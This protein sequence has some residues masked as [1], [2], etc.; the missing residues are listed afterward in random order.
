M[1]RKLFCLMLLCLLLPGCATIIKDDPSLK[2]KPQ[3]FIAPVSHAPYRG[4]ANIKEAELDFLN[5]YD[6]WDP[7]NR[8]IYSFNA[9]F[10]RAIYIPAMDIYTT[11]LPLPVRHGVNNA[12]NNLNEV[13]SFTNGIL[14][15]NGHKVGRAF[16]R[17]LINSS[18][19]VLGIF[20]VA[21]MW[22]LK[23]METG[24]ADTLGV[25][26]V[27]PGPYVVLP[28]LGP[29]SVRDSG[30][31]LGD[32]ALLYYEMNYLYDLA[33]VTDGRTEIA[34]GESIIRGLNLRANVPFRYYQTGSPFEYDMIRFLYSKKRELDMEREKMGITSGERPYMKQGFDTLRKNREPEYNQ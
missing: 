16:S 33:G 14:Q 27:P 30:G 12:I 5:V 3:G 24:F 7:M 11:V 34:I 10:D 31:A 20:D 23:K 22:D 9:R 19:G 1:M 29:S 26:G 18:I 2:L 4:K 28:L 17:F 25:W 8:Y 15:F 6:P 32:F 13:K 21:S